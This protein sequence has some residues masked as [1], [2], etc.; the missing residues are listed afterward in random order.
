MLYLRDLLAAP[1]MDRAAPRVH[2]YLPPGDRWVD[3]WTTQQA[4][5]QPHGSH[6]DAAVQ[7]RPD[8]SLEA[9]TTHPVFFNFK[10]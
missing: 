8:P 5:V 3:A 10:L 4:P 1:V 2:V 7:A 6:G 9:T